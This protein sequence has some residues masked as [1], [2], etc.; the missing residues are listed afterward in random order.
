MLL[1]LSLLFVDFHF[2]FSSLVR[3]PPTLSALSTCN[4]ICWVVFIRYFA[5]CR[6]LRGQNVCASVYTAKNKLVVWKMLCYNVN[7]NVNVRNQYILTRTPK[8][9]LTA[10]LSIGIGGNVYVLFN[11]LAWYMTMTRSLYGYYFFTRVQI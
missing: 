1:L 10:S 5:L 7:V 6:M 3:S 11:M 2:I 8:C 4:K 9:G